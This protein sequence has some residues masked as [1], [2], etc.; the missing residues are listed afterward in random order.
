MMVRAAEIALLLIPLLCLVTV[1]SAQELDVPAI[2]DETPPPRLKP[3]MTYKELRAFA[4]YGVRRGILELGRPE[5]EYRP[6]T[7]HYHFGNPEISPIW[8]NDFEQRIRSI[9]LE[10][11]LRVNTIRQHRRRQNQRQFW[12]PVLRRVERIISQM[13]ATLNSGDLQGEELET[14]ILNHAR[15]IDRLYESE[16]D[17]IARFGGRTEGAH[18]YK[19]VMQ[20]VH[21]ST[22]LST[23]PPTGRIHYMTAGAWE[24]YRFMRYERGRI[25]YRQPNWIVVS[26]NQVERMAGKYWFRIVWADGTDQMELR[27]ITMEGAITFM[28]TNRT[29]GGR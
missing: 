14:A 15:R 9:P 25:D 18:R 11:Q 27:R 21:R 19:E 3:G 4:D 6:T 1:T 7:L 20:V 13:L 10:H 28:P 12:D 29:D 26:Q 2:A 24:L 5:F 16:L 23:Q 22:K 17:R 8:P